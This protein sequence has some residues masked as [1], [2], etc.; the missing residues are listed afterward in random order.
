[1]TI[2]ARTDAAA[3]GFYELSD[4]LGIERG[5]T[6]L[7]R[8]ALVHACAIRKC[9]ECDHSEACRAW[10]V[11]ATGVLTAPPKGCPNADLFVE[12]LYDRPAALRRVI[13]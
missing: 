5:W 11:A 4:R 12:L 9:R 10:L 13:D 1:M 7:P 2:V 6:A 3:I 8:F